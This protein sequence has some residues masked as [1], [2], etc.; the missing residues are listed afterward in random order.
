MSP[1]NV[2]RFFD[3][4]KAIHEGVA[5][6]M[7][8]GVEEAAHLRIVQA[9]AEIG[10]KFREHAPRPVR[11]VDDQ[12]ARLGRAEQIAQQVALAALRPL[13]IQPTDEQPFGGWPPTST[14]SRRESAGAHG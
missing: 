6:V 8:G 3:S 9:A 4:K 11:P 12:R 2:Y 14:L 5:R 1:A 13:P 7:M 10:A